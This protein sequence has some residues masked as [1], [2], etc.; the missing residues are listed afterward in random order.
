MAPMNSIHCSRTT[1][2]YAIWV[3]FPGNILRIW[4]KPILRHRKCHY[5]IVFVLNNIFWF[6][7]DFFFKFLFNN[8][9]WILTD[10]YFRVLFPKKVYVKKMISGLQNYIFR[11]VCCSKINKYNFYTHILSILLLCIGSA[12]L[13]IYFKAPICNLRIKILLCVNIFI[14][15]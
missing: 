5:N 8:L 6:L 14:N 2:D 3:V 7:N 11:N 9:F 1:D 12:S 4:I 13:N 10:C 15:C